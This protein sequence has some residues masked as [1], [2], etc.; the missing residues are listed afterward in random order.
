MLGQEKGCFVRCFVYP[1]PHNLV[2]EPSMC[3]FVSTVAERKMIEDLGE[4]NK[5]GQRF[6]GEVFRVAPSTPL[7]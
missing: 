1:P 4:A 7:V 6:E 5:K 2:S 3:S